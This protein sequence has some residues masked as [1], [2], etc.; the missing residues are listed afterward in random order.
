MPQLSLLRMSLA[1]WR[2]GTA[3]N[4]EMKSINARNSWIN[5][6][7]ALNCQKL[8]NQSMKRAV[9]PE[10]LKPV[11]VALSPETLKSINVALSNDRNSEINQ[12]SATRN[13]KINQCRAQYCQNLW[14]Q[15]MRRSV[16]P[17]ARKSIN[18]ALSPARNIEKSMRRSELPETLKSINAA[19][20]AARSSWIN[21]CSA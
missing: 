16:L 11:N 9:P 17:E 13:S 7:S 21:Q 12:S 10:T 1:L 6:Y 20:S 2:S 5:Q 15:W 3:R 19:L 8:L 14:N 18:V 4:S